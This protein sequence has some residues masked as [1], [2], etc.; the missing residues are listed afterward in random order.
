M[1]VGR[2]NRSTRRKPVPVP[3]CPPQMPHDMTRYQT[4]AAAVGS[5][6]VGCLSYGTVNPEDHAKIPHSLLKY[7]V[8]GGLRENDLCS[9]NN[10]T[11]YS[12]KARCFLSNRVRRP[13]VQT[14]TYS[15]PF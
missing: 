4:R 12:R 14:P 11:R 8:V 7:P 9:V 5:R 2:G 6:R 15:V 13:G 3:L 10:V 1:G